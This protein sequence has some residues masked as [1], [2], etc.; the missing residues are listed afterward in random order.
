[1]AL[2]MGLGLSKANIFP[3]LPKELLDKLLYI[4]SSKYDM[5]DLASDIDDAVITVSSRDWVT[6]Y[7][8][9]TTEAT[10]SIPDD[11]DFIAADGDDEFWV[12]DGVIQ[13]KTFDDLIDLESEN[14]IVKYT[15]YAP[16]RIDGLAIKHPDAVWTEKDKDILTRYFKLWPSHFGTMR[17]FGYMKD[18]RIFDS[19]T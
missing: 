10:F 11:E 8:P 3:G 5:D 2:G 4:W 12:E 19:E 13:E 15:G 6:N 9:E 16:Y 14:T 18:N 17:D 7:I 1:M